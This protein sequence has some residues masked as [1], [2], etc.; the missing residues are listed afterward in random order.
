MR[1]VAHLIGMSLSLSQL[2]DAQKSN[3]T[4]DVVGDLESLLSEKASV[5]TNITDAHRWSEYNNPS[6]GYIVN[7][8]EELDVAKTVRY[9]NENNMQFLAQAGGNGWATTFHLTE[10]DIIINLR[11]LNSVVMHPS[12]DR[13]T[14][15]GGASN[16]E[17]GQVAYEN[18]RQVLSGGCNCV[19]VTGLAL[20]GGVSRWMN[21]YGMPVD[22]VISANVVT[23]SGDLVE[24]SATSNSDLFWAILGAGPNF[25]IVTSLVTKAHPL[26]DEGSAWAGELIFSGDKLE[27]VVEAMNNL[28]ITENMVVLWGFS[29]REEPVITAQI[30][31]MPGDADAGREA[32]KP[33][34][35][36]G[37]DQE[38]VELTS[39][40]HLNDDTDGLC[41]DGGRKPGWFTG[42]RTFDYPTFQT[43]Y[44][45]FS[46]FVINTGLDGTT[47]LIECYSNYVLREIGS[48]GASY[49]HRDINYYAWILFGYEY[50]AW[51]Q[52][53]E[54]FGSRV[55]DLWRA[56]SGFDTQR[57][58]INFAHGDESL[59]EIYGESLPRLRELKQKWDP[60]HVFNQWFP[61][62]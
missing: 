33:L 4:L 46:E 20:G 60:E 18:G 5:S 61:I 40:P 58:Y 57:T 39:Y 35:D 25:G 41:E 27:A 56:S 34:Y 11:G 55:R 38:T 24:A 42:L 47:I 36:I 14:V 54:V 44:N 53:V 1:F 16:Q 45:E 23:A 48:S 31:Y 15:G 59:E 8:A 13:I 37:P 22:N 9:C 7:V 28:N 50:A 6:P 51:D 3:G 26:I 30:L 2:T 43:M 17:W 10:R 32:F 12:G 21:L 62:V 19:G 29:Y 49:A 52:E